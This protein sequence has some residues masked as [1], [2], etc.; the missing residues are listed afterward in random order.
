[1]L[2]LALRIY[3]V[4]S[5]IVD[6]LKAY[7]SDFVLRFSTSGFATDLTRLELG[8][9]MGCPISP[10]LLVLAMQIILKA[11]KNAADGPDYG[12]GCNMPLLKAF[13]DDTTVLTTGGEAERTMLARLDEMV[14]WSRMYFK[15]KKSRC[16]SIKA[17]KVIGVTYEVAGQRIPTVLEE[18][19]KSLGR[20]YD[21][22]L[23]DRE[24][25]CQTVAFSKEGLLKINRCRPLSKFKAWILQ[26]MLVP[27]LLWS[28][29]V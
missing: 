25:I 23:G 13:S 26:F 19:V 11:A 4:P 24:S 28:L 18:S 6:M 5:D 7:F 27:K 17:G 16:L 3:K 29:L 8:I 12:E 10:I 15:P 22:S 2:W 1:M 9:T 14:E 20:V 21:S